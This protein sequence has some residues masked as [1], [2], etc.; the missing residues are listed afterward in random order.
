MLL[1]FGTVLLMMTVGVAGLQ[2]AP[3]AEVVRTEAGALK[4]KT[5]PDTK[6]LA[7]KGIPFAAPPVGALRWQPP[8]PA[9]PWT[10]TREALE[11]APRC[12]QGRIYDDMVFRDAGP[13][14]DCLYLNIWTPA[15]S[16]EEHMPVMVWIFG[17]G[18]QAGSPSEPRQ[19]GSNLAKKGVVVVSVDYRLGLFGFFSH[20]ELTR[21]SPHKA[22]GNYGLM[23]QAAALAWVHKNIGAFG[24][25]PAN[26]TIFGESAGSSSVSA[27]IATPLSKGLFK[28]AIG[29]SGAVAMSSNPPPSLAETERAGASFAQSIGA[30]TLEMLRAKPAEELLE[31]ALKNKKTRFRPNVDGYFFPDNPSKIYSGGQQAHVALL[32]GWNSDEQGYSTLLNK[33]QPTKQ[34]YVARLRELYGD[35][36]NA[37]S[38]LY[39]G[40]TVEEVKKSARDLASDRFIAF[41]TWKW[42]DLQLTTG[43][44]PVYRYHFERAAPQPKGEP[45]HGA[46]H[47]SDIEY[48][49]ETLDSKNLPWTAEDRKLSDVISSYWTNFAKTGDPNS[50]PLPK[51]PVYSKDG[52]QVMH[53][54]GDTPSEEPYAA[55]DKLRARYELLDRLGN[56]ASDR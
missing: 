12:M 56:R 21:E 14:E 25:D 28:Q 34:A 3:P 33:E 7:F 49:F 32:A 18:F 55:P 46:Y 13:S 9:V 11:F 31:A 36:A 40:N 44:S 45:S 48:V 38:E 37:I 29:E 27:Q 16:G 30:P 4:G 54:R 6:V 50:A 10:G 39:P 42:L 8:Q 17:G 20:P 19:D 1:K 15:L 5:N 24:G 2:C 35:D 22:S 26:V 43:G 41:A 53:L 23:D 52:Y 47:S 51:W